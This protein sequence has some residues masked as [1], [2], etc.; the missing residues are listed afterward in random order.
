MRP[1]V[2]I[3][4]VRL[5]GIQM[6]FKYRTIWHPTYFG[7]IEYQTSSVFRSPLYWTSLLFRSFATGLKSDLCDIKIGYPNHNCIYNNFLFNFFF[8]SH[9]PDWLSASWSSSISSRLS[10]TAADSW[11]TPKNW[12]L[13][14]HFTRSTTSSL[15]WLVW[16]ASPSPF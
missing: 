16:A 15:F 10:S 9:T 2:G 12:K 4:I 6:E 3:G 7:P 1:F 14:D 5:C 13:P 11:P 8:S